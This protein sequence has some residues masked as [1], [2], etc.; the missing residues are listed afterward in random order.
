VNWYVHRTDWG[1]GAREVVV[2]KRRGVVVCAAAAAACACALPAHAATISNLSLLAINGQGTYDGTL[3]CSASADGPSW[4]YSW[5]GG[6]FPSSGTAL[7]GT[8][9]GTVEVHQTDQSQPGAYVPPGTGRLAVQTQSL[10]SMNFIF[11][12]GSCTDASMSLTI[13]ASGD[14]F[15]SGT[16]PLTANGGTGSLRGLTGTGTA[17]AGLEL[18][19]GADNTAHILISGT[20]HALAPAL[21]VG[22]P[23]VFWPSATQYLNHNLSVTIPVSDS[24]PYATT[25]DAFGVTITRATL[26]AINPSSGVPASLGNIPDGQGRAA[27]VTFHGATPGQHYT[28]SV[29]ATAAD[30]LGDPGPTVTASFPVTAPLTP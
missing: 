19:P 20:F 27:T 16:L 15:A 9:D 4:L 14:P 29:T 7:R 8:W 6:A 30:A 25:G 24:G 13:D 22:G 18:G 5:Q 21:A 1:N 26:S 23:T 10:G 12:G 17:A 11:S 3:P 2:V 28:L